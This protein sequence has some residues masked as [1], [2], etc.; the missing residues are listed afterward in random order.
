MANIL[1]DPSRQRASAA[2]V[3]S[4][5]A[6]AVL[7]A[8]VGLAPFDSARA[9]SA[10]SPGAAARFQSPSD[11]A[12]SRAIAALAAADQRDRSSLVESMPEIEAMAMRDS[13]R[14]SALRTLMTERGVR[15]P[16]DFMNAAIIMQHGDDVAASRLAVSW[17]DSAWR[18]QPDNRRAA[19]LVA[20]TQDR[21]LMRQQLPQWYGTQFVRDGAHGRW[22]LYE[23][24]STRV[25]DAD[26]QRHGVGTLA[27]QRAKADA[28]NRTP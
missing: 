14:R 6:A 3:R 18:L 19:N 5:R 24:D 21:L 13:S 4:A 27:E 9:Q 8:F 20:I 11:S 17:A 25:T 10:L 7:V 26:R 28:M 23:V 15:S 1:F 16:A 22:R 12:R 2:A